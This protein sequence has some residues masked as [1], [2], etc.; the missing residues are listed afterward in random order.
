VSLKRQGPPEGTTWGADRLAASTGAANPPTA[1]AD[2]VTK[3]PSDMDPLLLQ[4]EFRT[5]AALHEAQM[6]ETAKH[7]IDGFEVLM[8]SYI[9]I[10]APNVLIPTAARTEKLAAAL[11]EIVGEA[12]RVGAWHQSSGRRPFAHARRV[13]DPRAAE[14]GVER[15]YAPQPPRPPAPAPARGRKRRS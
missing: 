2:P 13:S 9:S 3:Q 6:R 10:L 5:A 14:L 8:G 1:D 7:V 12:V 15:E 4:S 11:G